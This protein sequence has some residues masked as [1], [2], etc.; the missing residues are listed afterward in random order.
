[1]SSSQKIR[2]A[3]IGLGHIAQNAIL[4]AFARAKHNSKVV[5]LVSND[6]T[7]LDTLGMY[8]KVPHL[9]R[10][11]QLQRLL[12]SGEIDV[13]YIA[14]PN[15]MHKDYAIQALK[16]SVHVLCEKPLATTV[17]DCSSILE[18]ADRAGVYVMAAYRLHFDAANLSTLKMVR[19]GKIGEPRYF[20]SVFSM[21]VQKDN[22]RLSRE[23]G[24]GT[25][26]DIGVY[27]I[28]AARTLFGTEPIEVCAFESTEGVDARFSEVAE[29][30][31]AFMRFDHDRLAQFTVGFGAAHVS[32]FR[33]VGTKG[34]IQLDPAFQYNEKLVQYTTTRGKTAKKTFSKKDQFAAELSYFSDCIIK[35]RAPEPSAEEGLLDVR[36]IEA[37]NQSLHKKRSIALMP[38]QRH[39]H[40]TPAQRII[41]PASD[42][43]PPLVHAQAPHR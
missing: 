5:A 12:E 25:L 28:N 20:S 36:V 22:I 8:Y 23:H 4:P 18:Q 16:S 17:S 39:E 29:T 2:Y 14:L 1:M 43:Q 40:H 21:Q 6:P 19:D 37:L 27:C 11:E 32:A 10:Y 3:V 42:K 15:S 38:Y 24:G 26:Y 34:H 41:L 7:K 31:S 13:A 9:C 35:R 30:I 33:I